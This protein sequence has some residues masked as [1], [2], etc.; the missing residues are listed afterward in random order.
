MLRKIVCMFFNRVRQERKTV[1]GVN[2]IYD[3]L[4]MLGIPTDIMLDAKAEEMISRRLAVCIMKRSPPERECCRQCNDLRAVTQ[5][6]AHLAYDY[7]T[8][9]YGRGSRGYFR[10]L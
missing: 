6:A 9:D 8:C 7:A 3:Q 1:L 2:G 5:I 4:W 10:P